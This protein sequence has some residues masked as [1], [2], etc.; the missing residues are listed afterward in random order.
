MTRKISVDDCSSC[1]CNVPKR[2]PFQ[3]HRPFSKVRSFKKHR[4]CVQSKSPLDVLRSWTKSCPRPTKNIPTRDERIRLVRSN[5][6]IRTLLAHFV[7]KGV[8]NAQY[9]FAPS[10]EA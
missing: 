8:T 10:N 4:L 7:E 3:M 2:A 1:Y 5:R 6:K 9:N